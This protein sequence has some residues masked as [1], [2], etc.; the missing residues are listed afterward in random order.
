MKKVTNFIRCAIGKKS[1]PPNYINHL[2]SKS[3]I[4]KD[5]YKN[6]FYEFD[7]EKSSPKQKR[8]FVYADAE[9]LLDAVR[10]LLQ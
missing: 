3:K 10:Y 8:P 5:V 9:E 4:L 7:C 2:S 1:I 6:G